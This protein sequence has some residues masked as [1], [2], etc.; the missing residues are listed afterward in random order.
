MA[1]RALAVLALARGAVGGCVDAASCFFGGACVAGVCAC[2]AEWAGPTCSQLNLAPATGTGVAY[3]PPSLPA[4]SSWGGSVAAAGGAFFMAVAEM[5]ARCGLDSWE[6]NSAIRLARAASPEGPFAHAA[7]LLPHFAHNPTLHATANGSLV[8]AHIG[9]GVPIKPFI[10]NC[11]NGTTPR[12]AAPA[13]A[14]PAAAPPL[15]LGVPNAPL[16]PPNFL[17]LASGDPADGSAWAVLNST[18]AWAENNPALLVSADDSALLV[19]KVH[20]DCPGGCFCAQFGVATAPHWAGPYTDRG[21]ID[22]FGEDAYIWR[23]PAGAPGGGFH[24]LFQGGNY[25]PVYPV[26]TGHWHTA[27]S[28]DGLNWTVDAAAVVFNGTVARTRGGPLELYRRERHQVLFVNGAP[29]FLYNGA[30]AA[31]D[32]GD[33]TFTAVQ[34]VRRGARA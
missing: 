6:S 24:M 10:S 9:Q 4:T 20:C 30:M 29:A 23:D 3:P 25:A 8:I 13:A 26:Y 22:V 12:S 32:V 21:L 1:A 16:P 33:A 31:G 18:S 34:P 19:Y 27:A 15:R 28:A 5:E 7:L 2:R 14:A 17:Y 11:T